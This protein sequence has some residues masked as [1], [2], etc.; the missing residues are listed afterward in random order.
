MERKLI[1]NAEIFSFLN[2]LEHL[3]ISKYWLL[4]EANFLF[5][6]FDFDFGDQ[7]I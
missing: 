1:N 6:Y 4:I 7:N 2:S 5:F 3:D